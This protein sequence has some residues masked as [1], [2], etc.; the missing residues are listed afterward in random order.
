[1]EAATEGFMSKLGLNDL[2]AMFLCECW[3][4]EVRTRAGVHHGPDPAPKI[5]HGEDPVLV[6]VWR[7]EALGLLICN[8]ESILQAARNCRREGIERLAFG[9]FG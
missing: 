3:V 9:W 1:L 8:L 5:L 7:T 4:R 6:G 2:D